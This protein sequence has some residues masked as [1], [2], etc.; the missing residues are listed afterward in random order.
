MGAFVTSNIAETALK[1]RL[2]WKVTAN[3]TERGTH[4]METADRIQESH[5]L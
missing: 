2:V 4:E 3:E 1:R 5:Y